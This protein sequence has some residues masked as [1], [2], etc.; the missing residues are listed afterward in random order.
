MITKLKENLAQAQARIKKCAD[1]KRSE[2]SFSEGDMVYLK[3]QPFRHHAFALHQSLKLT[4]KYYRP[5]GVLQKLGSTAYKI[6]LPPTT[7]IHPVFHVSQLKKHMG[8]KA[9]PQA[10]LPLVTSEGY[11]KSEPVAVLDT[12]ALPRQ[13]EIV[14]QWK[15]QWI[16]LSADQA[17]IVTQWINLSADQ[18][19]WEDT[20]F[21]K[22]TFPKF[23]FKTLR[24]WWPQ[25]PSCGQELSQGGENCQDLKTEAATEPILVTE[26]FAALLLKKH[27]DMKIT[28]Q[29]Y[30]T[31]GSEI[32]L[33]LS[34][35]ELPL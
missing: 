4:T 32:A 14:T 15:I 11:I 30:R 22:A 21:I 18:A 16:N 1:L 5:F 17:E 3:L 35:V 2:R 8:P 24:E 23:Y 25:N 13:D 34:R 12:R 20:F 26:F 7:E 19:T 9:V 27:R 33:P 29:V 10:N 28:L 31:A 6:Q